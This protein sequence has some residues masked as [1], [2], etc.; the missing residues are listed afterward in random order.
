MNKSEQTAINGIPEPTLRRLPTYCQVLRRLAAQDH[1]HVSCTQI[2]RELNLD[3]TQVRKD[4][5]LAGATGRPKV[6]YPTGELYRSIETFLG[7]NDAR[8]AVL[9][10]AGSLGTALLGYT[11]FDQYG[12]K[13]VAAFDVDPAK[14]NTKIHGVRVFPLMKLPNLLE[15]LHVHIGI[16]TVPAEAAQSVCDQMTINGILAIWNFAPTALTV[17]EGV[18]VQN[19]NLFSSLG[20]LSS[21]LTAALR[22][23]GTIYSIS[24]ARTAGKA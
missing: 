24:D 2:G 23:A 19:E 18:I 14:C 21:K 3:P 20:I 1:E 7:W 16:L 6:G 15:R 22:G 4:L 10:G 17:P 12:V 13:I 11:P 8:D 9:V 5:S